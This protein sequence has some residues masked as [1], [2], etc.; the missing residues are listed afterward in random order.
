MFW[1]F[2]LAIVNSYIMYKMTVK[3]PLT[4]VDFRCNIVVGLRDGLTVGEVTRQLMCHT[5][6]D[7]KFHRWHYI[8]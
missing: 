6:P 5:R 1:L 3:K 4:N 7:E 2:N 8:E